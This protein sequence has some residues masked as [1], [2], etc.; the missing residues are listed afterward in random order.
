M[1]LENQFNIK[2]LRTYLPKFKLNE[3]SNHDFSSDSIR[4]H[5][6]SII[7]LLVGNCGACFENERPIWNNLY[8]E[9]KSERYYFLAINLSSNEDII[10][11]YFNQNSLAFPIVDGFDF[12]NEFKTNSPIVEIITLVVDEYFLIEKI[13]LSFLG[14]EKRTESFKNNLTK[15]LKNRS[16]K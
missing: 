13:H 8:H 15:S 6:K 10:K 14:D 9:L 1:N 3:Q 7:L 5:K 11:R 16:I 12:S 2:Y 4:E